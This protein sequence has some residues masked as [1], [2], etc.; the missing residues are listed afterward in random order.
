MLAN[1][2]ALERETRAQV[3]PWESSEIASTQVRDE[4]IFALILGVNPC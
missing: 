2:V 1:V 3:K 4:E